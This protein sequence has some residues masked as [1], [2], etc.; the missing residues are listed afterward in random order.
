M[1]N[2]ELF[3]LTPMKPEFKGKVIEG[4]LYTFGGYSNPEGELRLATQ[5]LQDRI[6]IRQNKEFLITDPLGNFWENAVI[7]I[8]LKG[9]Q[10]PNDNLL[11]LK[12]KVKTAE[13]NVVQFYFG[14]QKI[15]EDLIEGVKTVEMELEPIKGDNYLHIRTIKNGSILHFYEIVGFLI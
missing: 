12:I 3:K 9:I 14:I 8:Q 5:Y 7:R 10:I 1:P 15:K 13:K 4:S 11:K 2:E 6:S